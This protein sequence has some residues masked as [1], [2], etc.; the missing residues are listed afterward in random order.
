MGGL[1]EGKKTLIFSTL[2]VAL[3]IF[4]SAA[5]YQTL[6]SSVPVVM[7]TE[8]FPS[9]GK[10]SAP[11]EV[12]LIEDF[13]CKNCRAFSQKIIP[14]IQS[15]YVKSGKVRFTLVPVSFLA[16]SQAI[17][18]AALEVHRQN[19]SQ[20]FTFLKDVLIHDGPIQSADLIRLARRLQG[21]NLAQLENCIATGCH[22]H[23]L[24]KNLKWAM[25]IMGDQ[26]RT[27][28]LYV[29]GAPGSTYSFEAIQYQV[30]QLL[31]KP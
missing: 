22:N 9:M 27:P 11:I 29:N 26:F 25:G 10:S 3:S 28:A 17:A 23:E 16:G 5:I 4:S 19:S 14:K 31:A 21:I 7:Q 20:F 13:Q 8:G 6:R 15:Q 1:M 18:N 30:E 12:V 2:A 24:E